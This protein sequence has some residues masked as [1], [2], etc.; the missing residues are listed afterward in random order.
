MLSCFFRR[1]E[2][3]SLLAPLEERER[4]IKYSSP[5]IF[6]KTKQNKTTQKTVLAFTPD[7]IPVLVGRHLWGRTELDTTEAT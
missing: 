3:I 7:T 6:L 1:E 4:D 5:K 2:E